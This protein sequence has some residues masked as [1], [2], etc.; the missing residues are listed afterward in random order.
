MYNQEVILIGVTYTE[1]EIGNQVGTESRTT[2]LAKK[3]SVS[4]SEFYEAQTDDLK[5]ELLFII[6]TFEYTGESLLIYNG[7]TY[8]I[9]RTYY[10]DGSSLMK[11][12]L[13]GDEVEITCGRKLN[14]GY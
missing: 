11:N 14:N 13:K 5:P 10:G 4:Q 1:D 9:I 8:T 6:H 12:G 7:I 3:S 2:V